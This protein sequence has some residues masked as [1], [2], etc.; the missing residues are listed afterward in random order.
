M[1]KLSIPGLLLLILSLST[2]GHAANR[3]WVG[4]GTGNWTSSV[5][6][7][8]TSGGASGASA[9]GVS[10]LAFFDGGS[11]QNCTVN[12]T[13]SVGGINIGAAYAGTVSVNSGS[14]ITIG[15][16]GYTQSGGTF[17]GNTGFMNTYGVFV[18]AGGTFNAPSGTLQIAG[19]YTKSATGTFN[20]NSGTVYF[21]SVTSITLSGN[22]TFANLILGANSG[23]YTIAAGT[24]LTSLT[25]VTLT[26][27]GACTVNTGILAIQGDLTLQSS[28]NNSVNGGTAIFLFNGTGV[29]NISSA[30][31]TL[32]VGT[33]E[34][35][36]ALPNIEVN[37]LSGSLN[38]SG[39]ITLN[40]TSWTTTAGAGLINPGS[41]TVNIISDV[42]FSGQNL[43][44][45]NIHVWPNSQTITLTPATYQL[46][47]TNNITINGGGYFQFNTG[48]LEM[49]GDLTL[50]NSSGSTINGGTATLLIDG[51]GIQNINS[52]VPAPGFVCAL[53][54]V[55]INKTSGILNLN[56]IINFAGSS[57]NTVAGSALINPGTSTVTILKSSTLSG[58][59]L[60]LYN[61][62]IS[63]SYSTVVISSGVMWTS[64]NLITFAGIPWYQVN[65]G[66]LN[67]KGDVLVTCTDASWNVGGNAILL[68]D[69][70]A[71]QLLTGSGI[72]GAGRL[73]QVR[74]DKTGGVLTFANPIISTDNNWT[75]VQGAVDALT[76]ASTVDFHRT[77]IVDGQGTSSTMAF[78]NIMCSGAITLGG[79]FDVNG[80]LTIVNTYSDWKLDASPSNYRVNLAGNWINTNSVYT[81]SF[82]ERNG[83]VIFDGPTAQ[84]LTLA[85]GAHT[86]TFYNLEINNTSGGLTL[87]APIT[88][89]NN[90][91]FLSGNFYSSVTSILKF[92]SASTATGASNA[93]YVCGP[94]RKT[95]NQA[96]VFPVGKSS[97]YAPISISAPSITSDEFTGEYYHTSANP[98]YNLA[99]K[100]PTL[101]HLSQC[102]YW[103]LDRTIGTSNVIVRPSW[104]TRSCGVTNMADLRVARWDGTLWRDHGNGGTTGTTAAGTV[105][106]S[107]PVTSFSP[108]TLAS[109]TAANPLPVALLEFSAK[110]T[111]QNA[112]LEWATQTET[113]NDFFTVESSPTGAE[114]TILGSVPGAGNSQSVLQ[115]SYSDKQPLNG[116][117]YYRLTQTDA[118]G[119]QRYLETISL[120]ACNDADD[121]F[122]VYPNPVGGS[123]QIEYNGKHADGLTVF[124]Y[125]AVGEPVFYA[126]HFQ[127]FID[128]STEKAGVY[129]IQLQGAEGAVTKRIVKL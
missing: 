54:S 55:K 97:F 89:L 23:T 128:I 98:L 18:L 122:N 14:N 25:N 47:S 28:A 17:T 96:F 85:S 21:T 46:T 24:T 39:V 49:L 45:Y 93:S 78:N 3:Y 29:Q 56:G 62:T 129:F 102:E 51:T 31:S 68:F 42:T 33:N 44:L 125:N 59:N 26:G 84:Q 111:N 90:G 6:W 65:T 67:A 112:E 66:T 73:P 124:V 120:A 74:I 80:D 53:P 114:W 20:H 8:A 64:T 5:N 118:D 126:E 104:D 22:T 92:S 110:C 10:D 63:G 15:T 50:L 115:Y 37:K 48:I 41:S 117:S 123:F 88:I 76:N 61:I 32:L 4:I 95:G 121:T 12:S 72:A 107:A 99:L 83:K 94:V 71:N 116:I 52:S 43:S 75:Y 30:I 81:T 103:I 108:F 119:N 2:T 69:G 13:C 34:R 58:Q 35:V 16:S 100:D 70:T 7:S 113:N 82:E 40:G 19:S 105:V 77:S 91:N 9:P 27:G 38:L 79:N 60:S 36:C 109:I 86:E 87:N 106:S 1:Y 11:V 57:W 101:D 127:Q